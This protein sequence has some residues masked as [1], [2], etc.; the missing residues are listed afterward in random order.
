MIFSVFSKLKFEMFRFRNRNK[1][2]IGRRCQIYHT[3]FEGKNS[4][5]NGTKITN[6]KIGYGSY[7]NINSSLSFVKIGRYC[8]IADNVC[9]SIGN[10]PINYVSTHPA[11]YYNTEK[12]IGWTYH[13]GEPLFDE[14]YKYPDGEDFYQ[15]IIGNDVWIGSHALLMGG[16]RIGDGAIIASGAVVTRDVE[17]YSIVGGVPAKLIKKRFTDEQIAS[18]QRIKWWERTPNEIEN[19]YR[20]FV[21]VERFINH[22]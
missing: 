1:I 5:A 18:L 16:I 17:P 7:I 4:V 14:I 22:D 11:F 20:T 6:S 21:D 13:K 2:R 9:V 15:V 19:D 12:Q 3:L 10:H 8:S